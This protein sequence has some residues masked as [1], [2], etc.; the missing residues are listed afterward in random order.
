MSSASAIGSD[1]RS[2]KLDRQMKELLEL[3]GKF[4]EYMRQAETNI[5]EALGADGMRE[6]L[7][8]DNNLDPVTLATIA[9]NLVP[10]RYS[11]QEDRKAL[12]RAAMLLSEAQR[13]V[14]NGPTIFDVP[15]GALV[16]LMGFWYNSAVPDLDKI[17]CVTD[18]KKRF[19]AR[20]KF[21]T[22]QE[23]LGRAE[24]DF[25][26]ML[27]EWAN[28]RREPDICAYKQEFK[29]LLYSQGID[30]LAFILLR[31]AFTEWKAKS[32]SA[33]AADAATRKKS[34]HAKKR[35]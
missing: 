35:G 22:R 9:A 15:G 19:T 4:P 25:F 29:E 14:K 5:K 6:A 33:K 8:I 26:E 20:V 2:G 11:Q 24:T 31:D 18:R 16:P 13:I 17:D 7:R 32:K 23:K 3:A 27:G 10:R 1:L 34:L 21:V 12:V 28:E 30:P